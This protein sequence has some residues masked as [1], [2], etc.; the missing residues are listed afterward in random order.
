M[1]TTTTSSPALSFRRTIP[2]EGFV[3][4]FSVDERKGHESTN[5]LGYTH[6]YPT[7][8]KFFIKLTQTGCNPLGEIGHYGLHLVTSDPHEAKTI[9]TKLT[10][11][12]Q[13]RH[14]LQFD[15]PLSFTNWRQTSTERFACGTVLGFPLSALTPPDVLT[16]SLVDTTKRIR[17]H[18]RGRVQ[19]FSTE[20][21]KGRI[22]GT[23]MGYSRGS[24]SV[25]WKLHVLFVEDG[26]S[27]TGTIGRHGLHYYTDDRN[28]LAYAQQ[29]L[30]WLQEEK[31][32]I[33]ID[34]PV[35]YYQ[36][37]DKRTGTFRCGS[38]LDLPIAAFDYVP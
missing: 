16:P 4:L 30:S 1:D 8:W 9:E 6:H 15:A 25:G 29:A 28:D 10:E 19:L 34:A 21:R 14:L 24:G 11:L 37:M 36:W 5:P 27:P 13:S 33:E 23:P 7:S 18:L 35:N 32:L 31:F 2:L 26:C 17:I 3:N 12:Q 22:S 20:L 38:S